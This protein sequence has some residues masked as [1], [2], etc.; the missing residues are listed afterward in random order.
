VAA[1]HPLAAEAG[2]ALLRA[3]GNAVDA[4]AAVQFALNVVEPQYSGIG[5][6][7]FLLL[8]LA[9]TG[10]TVV[11]DGRETAPAASTPDQ[12][13]GPDGAPL[14]F[15]E[16]HL[17]GTAVGVPGT[18]QLVATALARFGTRPLAETLAPATALAAD[19][20]AVNRFL[21]AD[22][23]AH[24]AK[25]AAWPATAAI[26][27][28]DGQPLREGDPLRQPDL[29]HTFRLIAAGGPAVFYRGEIAQAIVDTQAQRGGRMTLADLA[30]YEVK[31]RTPVVGTYRGHQVLSMPPPSSG[32]LTMQHLLHLLEPLELRRTG[33]NTAPTLH[34]MVEAMRLAYADRAH[35]LGD[36]DFVAVPRHG[37]LHPTYVATR[38]A[39]LDPARANPDPQPGDP[40]AHEPAG[41]PPP[42]TAAPAEESGHTSHFVVVDGE[43]NVVSFTTTIE[44]AWG[45]G[46]VVPGYGFLLNNELTDFSFQPA[47]P[48][49]VEPGKRPRSSMT[50][51][52]VF[53]DGQPVLALGS[54][55]GSTIITTVLQVLLNVLEHGIDLQAA[56]DA[57]RLYSASY[58]DLTW[59]AAIP[60]DTLDALR[61]LGHQPTPSPTSLG[62]VQ[63][64]RRRPDGTWLGAADPRRAGTVIYVEP[65][66]A[67]GWSTPATLTSST[68]SI[69]SR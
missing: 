64:A 56:V 23:A 65:P 58:P 36:D 9:R 28:P 38:R 62:S 53:R 67:K 16:A 17:Q 18:L 48:N 25:L 31:E 26:F 39:L 21:A 37:L 68:P 4:A 35:Y 69:A 20:F 47:G 13:L 14:P 30:A 7:G 3:G 12:F 10:Q 5:G 61:A 41:A 43:G 63:A 11:L 24:H 29:A 42:A 46:L 44:A 50:P 45:S 1:S 19:G 22:V 33:H 55:G 51:T 66:A 8:Y 34:L 15:A 54:P 59:E 49:A 57:P 27:L 60:A 2:A 40:F 32:G 6:G 52:L